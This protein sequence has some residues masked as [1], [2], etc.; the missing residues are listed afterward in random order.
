MNTGTAH[1]TAIGART[2]FGRVVRLP[3]TV[4]A[5]GWTLVLER[6]FRPA[7]P[8]AKGLMRVWVSSR[9]LAFLRY[10]PWI[11]SEV[12]RRDEPKL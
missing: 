1:A 11:V 7:V 10:Q 4:L 12:A 3:H 6:R 8:S 5:V 2:H 9:G